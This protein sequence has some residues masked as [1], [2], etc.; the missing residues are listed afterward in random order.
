VTIERGVEL[1]ELAADSEGVD[2]RLRHRDGHEE[3]LCAEYLVGCDGAHSTVRK[4]AG[5]SFEG[6]A[7]LQDFMLGDVEADASDPMLTPGSLHSFGGRRETAMFFAL[8]N[9]RTWRV[10]AVSGGRAS[11]SATRPV[12]SDEPLTG[13]LTLPELQAVVNG[14][15]GGGVQLRDPA[16]L[17]HFRLHHRQASHY[18]A[19][20]VFIAVDPAYGRP[21]R[22]PTRHAR[23]A[24]P[25]DRFPIR[26]G[27]RD[28]GPKQSGRFGRRAV[29]HGWAACGRPAA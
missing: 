14:A 13:D 28:R 27:A 20:R 9:P 11:P 24:C 29:S 19:G 2:V 23:R 4:R 26:L 10:I 21:A 17:A 18:V 1:T 16:W 22:D 8:G 15:T 6:D 25:C 3:R 7:Y 12:A 5:I